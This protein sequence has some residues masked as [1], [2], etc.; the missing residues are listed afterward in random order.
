M[1]LIRVYFNNIW[2]AVYIYIMEKFNSSLAVHQSK[3]TAIATT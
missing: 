2:A 1:L 3:A